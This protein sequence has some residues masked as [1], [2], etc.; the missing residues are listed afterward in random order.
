MSIVSNQN[1]S[2]IFSKEDLQFYIPELC[3]YLVFHE[4]LAN[5]ELERLLMRACKIDMHFSLKYF[6]YMTALEVVNVDA[7]EERRYG[8]V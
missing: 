7:Y 3:T 8:K 5:L 1:E 6:F 4:E 2:A